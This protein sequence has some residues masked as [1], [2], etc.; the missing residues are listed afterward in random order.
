MH[1]QKTLKRK[2]MR[3]SLL[4]P[5]FL[6][7]VWDGGSLWA[8]PVL[9]ALDHPLQGEPVQVRLMTWRG[10]PA[11]SVMA[12]VPREGKPAKGMLYVL[13][14][15]KGEWNRMGR[16][17]LPPNTRYLEPLRFSG[18]RSGWLAMVRQQ[19]R[20]AVPFSRLD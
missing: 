6:M 17:E 14:V 2:R 4:I 13:T 10:A 15:K 20:I 16:W 9:V 3:I 18:G 5:I 1:F 8:K 12:E 7:A 19:W 11:I